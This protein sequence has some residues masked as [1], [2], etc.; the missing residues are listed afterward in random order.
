MAGT[1]VSANDMYSVI[2]DWSV[3]QNYYQNMQTYAS[4]GDTTG[5]ENVK[6]QLANEV[7]NVYLND[8]DDNTN[9]DYAGAM[10]FVNMAYSSYSSQNPITT[11]G[12]TNNGGSTTGTTGAPNANGGNFNTSTP[13]AMSSGVVDWATYDTQIQIMYN[14]LSGNEEE[15]ALAM[16]QQMAQSVMNA[17]NSDDDT[18]NDITMEQ[19]LSYIDA[20]YQQVTGQSVI[21]TIDETT[22]TS[23]WNYVPIVNC[24]VNETSAEDLYKIMEGEDPENVEHEEDKT[25]G[26]TAG[27]IAACTAAGA[28]I[29]TAVGGWAFGLGTVVGAGVGFAVGVV[30]ELIDWLS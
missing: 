29:G 30:N 20:R 2:K 3:Y 4:N 12:N 16:R 10:S 11:T 17:Y 21:A 15:E 14:R 26:G 18:T 22:K 24:F 27:T 19:A 8:G 9:I 28:T 25:A 6:S 5:L 1:T 23:F 13:T 7:C